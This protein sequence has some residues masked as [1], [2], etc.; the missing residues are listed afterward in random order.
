MQTTVGANQKY[1]EGKTYNS[2]AT[3]YKQALQSQPGALEDLQQQFE[4]YY[5]DQDWATKDKQLAIEQYQQAVYMAANGDTEDVRQQAA[6]LAQYW[7]QQASKTNDNMSK[8]QA[9]DNFILASVD[10]FA[11][12]HTTYALKDTKMAEK[13]H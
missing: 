5:G 13:Y 12:A 10:D 1:F 2:L 8:D 11:S 4:Y 9:F 3:A 6:Q 7:Q